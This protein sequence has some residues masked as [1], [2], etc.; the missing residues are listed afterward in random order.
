MFLLYIVGCVR[1]AV[2][3]NGIIIKPV[4]G[5]L[6]KCVFIRVTQVCEIITYVTFKEEG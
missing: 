1:A 5:D 3:V 4:E 2:H 6:N